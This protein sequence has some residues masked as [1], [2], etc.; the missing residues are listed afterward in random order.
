MSVYFCSL[1]M[2]A[3]APCG[4]DPSC[5]AQVDSEC[6]AALPSLFGGQQGLFRTAA[7]QSSASCDYRT[8]RTRIPCIREF[9]HLRAQCDAIKPEVSVRG[10]V[11]GIRI[12]CIQVNQ[13]CDTCGKAA[14]NRT[15]LSSPAIEW[16]TST[17]FSSP[18]L[19]D[20]GN[21]IIAHPVRRIGISA[22]RRCV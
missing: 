8:N 12:P 17:G 10:V 16:P 9:G 2:I 20:H 7:I 14:P 6:Q 5:Q 21:H 11:E 19:F 4:G 3:S 18:S 1:A 15:R 22:H 13:P